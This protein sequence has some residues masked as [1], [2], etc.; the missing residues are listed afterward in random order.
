MLSTREFALGFM[1]SLLFPAGTF[2]S[3]TG[4][5][6]PHAIPRDRVQS[7]LRNPGLPTSSATTYK[8]RV[9][10]V[11]VPVTITDEMNR[12][13]TGLEKKNFQIYENKRLQSISTCSSE[14]SPVSVGIVLDTSGSM[15]NKLQKAQEAINQFIATANPDDDFFLISFSDIP[16]QIADFGASPDEIGNQLVDV[17]AKGRTALLD[18]IYWRSSR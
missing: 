3:Q 9:N 5:D 13:V 1:L 14:D 18:A 2:S 11:L 15:Q 17:V 16:L 7:V 12:A 10:L 6:D 4:M 8:A